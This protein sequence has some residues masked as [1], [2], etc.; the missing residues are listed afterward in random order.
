MLAIFISLGIGGF[1]GILMV[2]FNFQISWCITV[3]FLGFIATKILT[4]LL[5]RKLVKKLTNNIQN[6]ITDGQQKLNKKIQFFQTKPQGGIK[7]MQ[8]LLE[9]D[10]HVFIRQALEATKAFE[11]LYLWNLLLKKQVNTMRMQFYYQLREFEKVDKLLPT[12]MYVDHISV[13]MKMVRLYKN[14]D[15]SYKK[16][17]YKKIKKFKNEDAVILYALYSWI[18]VK[19]GE[20][21]EAVIVLQQGKEKTKNEVLE[22]NWESLVNNKDKKFSNANLGDIWYA[23]YLEEVKTP[24]PKQQVI[25]GSSHR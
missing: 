24:K 4:G 11:K 22:K 8:K 18:L 2:Y 20:I 12:A 5:I 10:Q 25:R 15:K 9:K 6:I 14:E 1:L 16:L 3:G 21:E 19:K 13:A 17:F 23:L 7:T